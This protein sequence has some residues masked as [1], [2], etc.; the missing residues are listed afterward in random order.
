M[1]GRLATVEEILALI[2]QDP[3]Q[4][5]TVEN[6]VGQQRATLL[7]Y[8]AVQITLFED[9]DDDSQSLGIVTQTIHAHGDA[10]SALACQEE[11]TLALQHAAAE[12][13]AMAGD[14][15]TVA[16][17]RLTGDGGMFA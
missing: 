12:I 10:D 1:N 5:D 11:M 13:T 17:S 9:L 14:P 7:T 16:L 6:E 4:V 8:G 2:P 3:D 15:I